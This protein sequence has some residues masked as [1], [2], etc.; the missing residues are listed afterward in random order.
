[1]KVYVLEIELNG[2][3]FN[4]GEAIDGE[5]DGHTSVHA[6]LDGALAH[7]HDWLD[8]KGI[9]RETA[10]Y[11]EDNVSM[12]EFR[13]IGNEVDLVAPTGRLDWGINLMEVHA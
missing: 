8:I 13:F 10:H 9:D 5:Y 7:F 6:T 4:P 12:H 2:P 1:M 11:D 3:T